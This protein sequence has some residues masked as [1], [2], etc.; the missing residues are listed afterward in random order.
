MSQEQNIFLTGMMGTGKST[1]GN[2]LA[3]LLKMTFIDTD[4]YA[5]K[6]TGKTIREI[7]QEFGEEEFRLIESE[8]F[9]NK[10]RDSNQVFSTGGGIVI[11]EKNRKVLRNNGYTVLLRVH[12]KSLANRIGTSYTRPLLQNTDNMEERLTKIWNDRKSLYESTADL[13]IDAD[14]LTYEE[15]VKIIVNQL[16]KT[17]AEN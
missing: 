4:E 12:P 11:R 10:A 13:I 2:Q 9:Q 17:H 5:E 15:V 7:F 8:Y 6:K 1:V 16:K 3:K 14:N